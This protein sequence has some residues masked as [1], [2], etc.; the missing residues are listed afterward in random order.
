MPVLHPG[1]GH[2][3]AWATTTGELLIFRRL[4]IN[5]HNLPTIRSAGFLLPEWRVT[6]RTIPI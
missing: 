3:V 5:P 4:P 1:A 6:C 2:W